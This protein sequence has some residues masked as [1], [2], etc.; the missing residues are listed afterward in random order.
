MFASK[1]LK[2]YDFPHNIVKIS[3]LFFFFLVMEK[4]ISFNIRDSKFKGQVL[5]WLKSG[6]SG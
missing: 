1:I 5:S 3:G 6:S 2:S 4:N